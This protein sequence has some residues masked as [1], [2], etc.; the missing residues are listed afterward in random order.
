MSLL[1]DDARDV[2]SGALVDALTD[3]RSALA[4]VEEN[5]G[6][7]EGPVDARPPLRPSRGSLLVGRP[8]T[9]SKRL[10]SWSS[11]LRM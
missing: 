3:Y 8:S 9:S 2:Q 10:H 5:L 1:G 6:P 11:P 4:A 7:A